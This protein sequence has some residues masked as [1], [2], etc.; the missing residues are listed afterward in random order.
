MNIL[1]FILI[2][3]FILATGFLGGMLN[4]RRKWGKK[5]DEQRLNQS[6]TERELRDV[7][8]KLAAAEALRRMA[9]E[10]ADRQRQADAALARQRDE[11][12]RKEFQN[13]AEK[14]SR[15]Q[16]KN[17]QDTNREQMNALLEPLDRHIRD[18]RDKFASTR[19]S[20]EKQIESL[21]RQTGRVRSQ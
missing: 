9:R 14:V 7:R 13:L 12:L 8:E 3:F 20:L 19:E 21:L 16:G 11:T 10:D 4:E 6:A 2:A 15:E 5:L 1:L 18:F 17:L